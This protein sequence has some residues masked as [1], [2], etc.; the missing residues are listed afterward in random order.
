MLYVQGR[1][2]P[3]NAAGAVIFV[4]LDNVR[5]D[6][7]SLCGYP[8][9]TT[10]NLDKLAGGGVHSCRAYA[11]GTW[12]LP[13]HA[14]YF[15]GVPMLEHGAHDVPL[16]NDQL[17]GAT[18]AR[19]TG[20]PIR[21]LDER[22]P[23]LAEQFVS[24]GYQSVIVSGNPVLGRG[25]GLLRGF[26]HGVVPARF[27]VLVEKNA[28]SAVANTLRDELDPLGGPL[29][30]FLNLAE[31]HQPWSAVPADLGW[32]PPRPA[33]SF[34]GGGGN[35][36][37]ERFYSGEMVE[38]ERAAF[39]AKLTD[40]YDYG[41][42]RADRSLGVILDHLRATGWCA[43]DCRVVVTSDHGELLGEHGLIDHGF[44]PWEAN[45]RV[46]VV[47]AG[48][49]APSLPTPMSGVAVHELVWSGGLP[50]TTPSVTQAAFGHPHRARA[51]GGKFY[52]DR[53]AAYWVG[54]QKWVWQGSLLARFDLDADPGE[55]MPLPVEPEPRPFSALRQVVHDYVATGS[56]DEELRK[57]LEAAGY[58]EGV[59][60]PPA[61]PGL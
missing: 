49:S 2:G 46:P 30:L 37:W 38:E 14:S 31:A 33:L 1:V 35:Q 4:V 23:T 26:Q 32:A 27:G 12:T 10:P 11:P 57:Q 54:N 61:E 15:T 8:R 19:G 36:P 50:S 40:V 22:L 24:R 9:P 6:H 34:M 43:E 13:S 59:E 60:A 29:F 3:H 5:A 58:L 51:T 7:T 42:F 39:L 21:G 41:I 45:A 44:Y 28:V 25:S 56:A 48:V 16:A 18:Y 17:E 20:I 47:A 52:A 55:S 53:M